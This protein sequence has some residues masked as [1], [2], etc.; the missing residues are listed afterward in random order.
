MPAVGVVAPGAIRQRAGEQPSLVNARQRRRFALL[1]DRIDFRRLRQKRAH[2]GPAA[3]I[4][5]AEIVEGIGVAAFNDRIGFGGQFGHRASLAFSDN[6]RSA[7][8]SGTRS[9]SGR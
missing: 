5:Q 8:A 7:P 4:V 3:F 6:M 1:A 9:H 2:H